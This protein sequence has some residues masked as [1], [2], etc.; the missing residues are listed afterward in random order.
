MATRYGKRT[1]NI[2][3]T[4]LHTMTMSGRLFGA[5][6]LIGSISSAITQ[7][8]NIGG[9]TK[10]ALRTYARPAVALLRGGDDP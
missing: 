5:A 10:A 7:P 6:L 1:S 2:R 4:H 9:K 3:R 8:R